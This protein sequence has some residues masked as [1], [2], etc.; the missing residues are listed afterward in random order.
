M[1][2]HLSSIF[3]ALCALLTSGS[4]SAQI[5]THDVS[6]IVW[7]DR[8][9]DGIRTTDE[10]LGVSSHVVELRDATTNAVL[11]TT[12][13]F[14][15]GRYEFSVLSL[16]PTRNYRIAVTL[17]TSRFLAF[18]P[19]RAGSDPAID[20]DV[21]PAGGNLAQTAVL[22]V[23]LGVPVTSIDV[24]LVP[25]KV[26]MGNLVWL[27]S[28]ADGLQDAGEP[29]L[30]GVHVEAWNDARTTRYAEAITGV[31]GTYAL[32]LPGWGVYRLRFESPGGT[33]FTS[34]LIGNDP[35]M[36]SDVL[37]FGFDRAWTDFLDIPENA[38]SITSIDAGYLVGV[39]S[40][41]V[42]MDYSVVPVVIYPGFSAAWTLRVREGVG[43]AID[44]VRVRASVPAGIQGMSWT[45]QGASG[46]VCPASGTN[47]VDF[48]VPMSPR[49]TMTI[50][51]SG[52]VASNIGSLVTGTAEAS[53]TAPQTDVLAY[54][55]TA[56]VI[57]RNDMLFRN[58][59]Q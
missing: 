11:S 54:N 53:V 44:Q 52:Q 21:F 51:F 13:T 46:T 14:G 42:A 8:V 39:N 36:D 28:D 4:V 25:R 16:T 5:L 2:R 58:G 37:P 24:G 55:S 20:S 1:S 30:Q 32:A 12:T 29:R 27:D 19:P 15:S 3:A 56:Q 48:S 33:S 31:D 41:D 17:L 7:R 6:G 43:R 49:G 34:R 26:N 59:F 47:A 38:L 10:N 45:C 18:S 40:V 22:T 35:T 23:T 57:L 50:T 9:P